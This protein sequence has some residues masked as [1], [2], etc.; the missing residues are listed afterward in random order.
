MQE[1]N[2]ELKKLESVMATS[3]DEQV[4]VHRW[5][6]DDRGGYLLGP[7]AELSSWLIALEDSRDGTEKGAPAY[8]L[9]A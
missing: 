6:L 1:L 8:D 4:V 2:H 7:K 9:A 3:K 5:F